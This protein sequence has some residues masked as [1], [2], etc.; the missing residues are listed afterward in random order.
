MD[1]ETLLNSA[2]NDDQLIV[3]MVNRQAKT[4]WEQLGISTERWTEITQEAVKNI[5][6]AEDLCRETFHRDLRLAE[7]L[8]ELSKVSLNVN[9]LS[10][11][12][13]AVIINNA[14]ET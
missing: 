2:M 4:P 13:A 3:T 6:A 12:S 5:D 1:V 14:K 8:V 7:R 11:L 9:E 10:L